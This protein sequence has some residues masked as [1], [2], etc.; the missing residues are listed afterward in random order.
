MLQVTSNALR[1]QVVNN[2][3]NYTYL[4]LLYFTEVNIRI[5]RP[6]QSDT[7][8]ITKRLESDFEKH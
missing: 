1:Q 6:V 3:G 7:D 2:E 8:Q 4:Q 5:C